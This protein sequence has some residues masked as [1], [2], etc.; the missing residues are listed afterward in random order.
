MAGLVTTLFVL[1]CPTLILSKQVIIQITQ[2]LRK[3]GYHKDINLSEVIAEGVVDSPASCGRLC[4]G[5][6]TCHSVMLTGQLCRMFQTSHCPV[7]T[8]IDKYIMTC[9]FCILCIC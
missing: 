5:N 2:K 1:L 9:E 8:T 4:E 3:Q 7:S 6:P